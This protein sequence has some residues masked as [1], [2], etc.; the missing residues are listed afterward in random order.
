MNPRGRTINAA[1]GFRRRNSRSSAESVPDFH[2]FSRGDA[3]APTPVRAA[4]LQN[5]LVATGLL[6][7]AQLSPSLPRRLFRE[8]LYR[9]ATVNLDPHAQT[10]P[11]L[12]GGAFVPA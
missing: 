5:D 8:D 11:K 1:I 3:N 2:V 12:H 6:P 7:R 10:H 9:E 4:T